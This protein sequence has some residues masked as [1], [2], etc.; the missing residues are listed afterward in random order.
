MVDDNSQL[1]AFSDKLKVIVQ[2][3]NNCFYVSWCTNP[4]MKLEQETPLPTHKHS[5]PHTAL[6]QIL[7]ILDGH[8]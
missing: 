6:Q 8:Q 1:E 5:N 2:A 4:P 7:L 3:K